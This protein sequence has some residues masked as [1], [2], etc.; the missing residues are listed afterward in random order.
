MTFGGKILGLIGL[1]AMHIHTG[2]PPCYAQF[3]ND[4]TAPI[5]IVADSM[6]WLNEEKIAIARGNADAVQGRYTLS[7]NVLTAHIAD[8]PNGN[9]ESNSQISLIEAEGNVLLITPN[10]K[11]RGSIGIYDVRN[12]TAILT[13]NVV[14]T[15][16]ENV[17]HGERLVMDLD[18]GHSRLEG[19]IGPT[20]RTENGRVK[21]IFNPENVNEP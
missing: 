12:K 4:S 2:L 10:E 1:C 8:G 13:G 5:E 19:A 17:L 15:Q 11:A 9:K 20:D 21:A 18:T 6:E 7:A 14:L 16:G 3:E